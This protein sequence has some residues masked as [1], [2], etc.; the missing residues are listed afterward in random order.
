MLDRV[1]D[2]CGAPPR[3]VSADNG[4]LS[5][6]NVVR[7]ASR[8]TDLQPGRLKHHNAAAAAA[9]PDG[10]DDSVKAHM[11][12]KLATDEGRAVYARRKVIVE[13]VFGQVGNRGFRQFSATRPRQ[14]AW[15]VAAHRP[16]TKPCSSCTP[17]APPRS[18]PRAPSTRPS[19]PPSDARRGGR[20]RERVTGT[21]S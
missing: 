3:R 5:E 15:R 7:E 11:K 6:D 13:P 8:G 18:R 12:A 20:M 14:G 17:P 1:V 9:A 2:N 4:Y 19:R 21:G 10:K 16:V